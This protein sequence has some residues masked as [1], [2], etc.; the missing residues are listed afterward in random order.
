[1]EDL[2]SGALNLI[3]DI[4]MKKSKTIKCDNEEYALICDAAMCKLDK[5]HDMIMEYNRNMELPHTYIDSAISSLMSVMKHT[6]A[7]FDKMGL[8]TCSDTYIKNIEDTNAVFKRIKTEKLNNGLL[9][10]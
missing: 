5:L 8:E 1:M 7:S 4:V 6:K 10:K 3:V 2:I 9:D